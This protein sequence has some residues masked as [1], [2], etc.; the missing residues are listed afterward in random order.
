[1]NVYS[2]PLTIHATVY[3]KAATPE[4]A[5]QLG[6]SIQDRCFEVPEASDFGGDQV[7]ISGHDFADP[8][9]PTVSL[10]PAMTTG[11]LGGLV[12]LV[13]RG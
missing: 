7:A 4:E 13:E 3:V 12:E 8:E 5:A 1:M 11:Q 10:S 6:R 9:L 2:I